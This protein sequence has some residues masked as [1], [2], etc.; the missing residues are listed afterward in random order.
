METYINNIKATGNSSQLEILNEKFTIIQ[1]RSMACSRNNNNVNYLY[2]I[3]RVIFKIEP[4]FQY[5]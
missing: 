2:H 4:K 5:M 1:Q 3:K